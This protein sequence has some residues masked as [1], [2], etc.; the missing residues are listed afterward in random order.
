MHTKNSSSVRDMFVRIP[1]AFA[2]GLA[3]GV[4]VFSMQAWAQSGFPAPAS[5]PNNNAAAPLNVLYSPQVKTGSLIIQG[6]VSEGVPATVGFAVQEGNVGIGT[7]TPDAKLDVDGTVIIRGGDPAPGKVLTSVDTDGNAVWQAV[8]SSGGGSNAGVYTFT[9]S[10]Y[11]I[12]R[13]PDFRA[14]MATTPNGTIMLKPLAG[15]NSGYR[16]DEGWTGWDS[17]VTADKLC[18]FFT[19][20]PSISFT[21]TN[22]GSD[23][24]NSFYRWDRVANAWR[25]N[26]STWNDSTDINT[27]T[28]LGTNGVVRGSALLAA[29]GSQ[30]G[31]ECAA[32]TYHCL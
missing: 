12:M 3:V 1:T 20:G 17:R 10:F 31:T 23:N 30:G 19:D 4:L 22:L 27:V 15:A 28:C 11:S 6:L 21:T 16:N 9:S 25:V 32:Q 18:N 8:V 26:F 29:P 2:F 14:W 7:L 13:N 5:P 24:N